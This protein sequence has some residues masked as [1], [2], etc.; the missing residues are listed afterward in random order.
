VIRAYGGKPFKFGREYLIPKPFDYRVLLWEAPAVA[1][2]AID[3]GLAR[4]PYASRDD[5]VRQLE[6][7][8]SRTRKVMHV[9][10]DHAKSEPK[11]IAFPEA[12]EPRIVRAAKIL[13]DEGICRPVLIGDRAAIESRLAEHDVDPATVDVVDPS[14]D[15]RVEQYA[16]RF[17]ELRWRHGI[18]PA[19]AS[20]RMRDAVYFGNMMVHERDADGLIAGLTMS[21]PETIRPALQIHHTLPGVSLVAG[22][23]L[24]LFEDRMLFIA[25]TTVNQDPDADALAEIAY[26]AAQVAQNYFQVDARV[27]LLS[28]S[29]FG[30]NI[31]Q[32]STKVRDAVRIA[33][34][35]WPE[36]VVE[37]E[38]QADAAVEPGIARESFPMS[39]IHGDANILVCP[40][41][42]SANIAYKLLWRLGKVEAIGPILTGIGA[43]VHVLQRGV[44]VNDIVNMTALC[45][46][47]AQRYR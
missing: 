9:V 33:N 2:A 27:A 25:D 34:Q 31:D 47:K 1:Q 4:K 28:Y 22:I 40:D 42:E 38:M 12:E 29:N 10:L 45:V 23:Y 15:D 30:S 14:R 19:G 8:L 13:V 5:Y 43:P 26:M 16:R 7:R 17:L 44:E 3:S 11:R 37:G 35:R 46:L 41:L 18:T 32:R 36:L 20:R 6:D 24:L 39:R 21:Y